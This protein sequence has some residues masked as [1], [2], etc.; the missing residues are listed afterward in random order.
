LSYSSIAFNNIFGSIP[1]ELWELSS[2]EFLDLGTHKVLLVAVC[3]S[4]IVVL[5]ILSAVFLQGRNDLSGSIPKGIS[6]TNLTHLK[7]GKDN[8][9]LLWRL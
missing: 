2:L 4:C 6:N 5:T 1:S 3:D 8:Y 7:L 9:A